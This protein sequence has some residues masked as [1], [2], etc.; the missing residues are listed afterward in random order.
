MQKENY[1][2]G[3][4]KKGIFL[5]EF[6]RELIRNSGGAIFELE[7]VLDERVEDREK[8]KE[9]IKQLAKIVE[10]SHG[11]DYFPKGKEKNIEEEKEDGILKELFVKKIFTKR[12]MFV[13]RNPE[14]K[15]SPVLRIPIQKLP[16]RFEYLEPTPTAREIELGKLNP[17]IK[18]P[19][20]MG[21]ECNGQNTEIVVTG[22]M[23]TKNTNIVLDES[24]IKE[25]IEKFSRA[26]KIPYGE[27]VFRVA[28]GKLIFLAIV[29]EEIG[30]KFVIKKIG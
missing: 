30:S 19:L 22:S 18:D 24:E 16:L 13:Q 20:V 3:E 17:L 15:F 27:G 21:I 10:D 4:Y 8:K 29:S 9:E 7:R 12:N 1:S 11:F 6:T 25:I 26:T 5:L 2:S 23:G 28:F 14:R